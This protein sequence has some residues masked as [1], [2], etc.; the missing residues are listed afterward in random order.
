MKSLE[1]SSPLRSPKSLQK[2]AQRIRKAERYDN[3]SRRFFEPHA[4]SCN[5]TQ[6]LRTRTKHSHLRK[7]T[8]IPSQNFIVVGPNLRVP[9]KSQ[10]MELSRAFALSAK[11]HT[12]HIGKFHGPSKGKGKG[13]KV[14]QSPYRP[15]QAQRVPGG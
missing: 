7:Y 13:K 5:D 12:R 4:N 11:H 8:K 10:K 3:Y 15:R 2:E 9:K 6:A 14:K 1:W